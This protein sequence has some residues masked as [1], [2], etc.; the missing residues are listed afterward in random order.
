MEH[1]LKD[2]LIEIQHN[3][4]KQ[5]QKICKFMI[6]HID[7]VTTMTIT[8]LS[9]RSEVGTTTILRLI[10]KIGYNSYLQF[11]NDLIKYNYND[12]KNT[13]WHLKKSLEELDEAE[14]SLVKAAKNSVEDIESMV[15]KVNMDEYHKFIEL[16]L[17]ANQVHFLGLRTSKSIALYF[18]MMLKGILDHVNQLSLH[19]DFLY[20]D[21]LCFNKNDVLVIIALSPYTKQTIDFITYCKKHT[22][23]S[24]ALIMDLETSPV[25]PYSDAHLIVGQ[26]KNRYSI[27]P[28]VTLIES[29]II[30]LGKRQLSSVEKI[31][32]LNDIHRKNNITTI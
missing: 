11:K 25:L 32:K 17:H 19:P 16:L 27:I 5:Q 15:K 1:N 30:D 28:T 26:S 4:P 13:W 20:D 23:V 6:N 18:E 7:E 9:E 2:K 22:D 21:S 24:I 14:T 10:E 31:S 8:E 29:L 3:L 12:K